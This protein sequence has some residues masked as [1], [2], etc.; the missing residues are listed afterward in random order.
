MQL[1]A[2]VHW[3]WEGLLAHQRLL[4]CEYNSRTE[5][6]SGQAQGALYPLLGDGVLR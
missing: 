2:E 1:S 3:R 6:P 4:N 5:A